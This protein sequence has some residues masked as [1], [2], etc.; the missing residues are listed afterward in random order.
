MQNKELLKN[1]RLQIDTLDKEILYLLSR[2]FTIVNEI[3]KIKKEEKMIPLQENRWNELL[4]ENIEVWI[5][6]WLTKDFVTDIWN[7]IHKMSLKIE[8]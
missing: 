5:E 6:L 3:W 8:K 4:A 7:I 1:F 2:R